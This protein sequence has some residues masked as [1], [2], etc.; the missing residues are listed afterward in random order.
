MLPW[1]SLTAFRQH[2]VSATGCQ[3]TAVPEQDWNSSKDQHAQWA[4]LEGA[5]E[6]AVQP[7]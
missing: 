7:P 5:K 4:C 6:G 3:P 2:L 1:L